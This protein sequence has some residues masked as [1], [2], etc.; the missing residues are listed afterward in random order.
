MVRIVYLYLLLFCTRHCRVGTQ[1]GL[2]HVKLLAL[3]F[4]SLAPGLKR[5]LLRNV[6]GGE[7]KEKKELIQMA[8]WGVPL[9]RP[10]QLS[11][12]KA[13]GSIAGK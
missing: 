8:V 13:P 12:A 2:L 11:S 7:A 9:L 6:R 10:F 4:M 1:E 5:V 3:V